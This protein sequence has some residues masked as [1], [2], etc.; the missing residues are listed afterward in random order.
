MRRSI[1]AYDKAMRALKLALLY[2]FLT[3]SICQAQTEESNLPVDLTAAQI[4]A[5]KP[6][7]WLGIIFNCDPYCEF[8]SIR[9]KSDWNPDLELFKKKI[10]TDKLKFI[11]KDDKEYPLLIRKLPIKPFVTLTQTPEPDESEI[12]LTRQE[13]KYKSEGNTWLADYQAGIQIDWTHFNTNTQIQEDLI[14]KS[15]PLSLSLSL[16]THW[17]KI[18]ST[19]FLGKR[20]KIFVSGQW[21]QSLHYPSKNPDQEITQSQVHA[22]SSLLFKFKH[23]RIGPSLSLNTRAMQ[24]KTSSLSGFSSDLSSL[25]IGTQFQYKNWMLL[26]QTNMISQIH[27]DQNFRN[28]PISHDDSIFQI[29]YMTRVKKFFGFDTGLYFLSKIETEKQTSQITNNLEIEKKSQLLKNN[30]SLGFGF[31]MGDDIWFD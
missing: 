24:T 5:L 11:S 9:E 7:E 31:R 2:L 29:E 22:L 16:S 27:D 30:Y 12:D 10:L 6:K 15:N 13:K 3:I 23:F 18:V 20:S 4:N 28:S 14:A 21:I 17:R 1:R 25:F 26:A 8:V 19:K